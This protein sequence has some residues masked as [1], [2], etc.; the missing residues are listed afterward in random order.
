MAEIENHMK[1]VS[2]DILGFREITRHIWNT[3]FIGSSASHSM[4]LHSAF[5]IIETELLNAIIFI[6][7]GRRSPVKQYRRS[8]LQSI[9][10]KPK[11]HLVDFTVQRAIQDE[12][13]NNRWMLPQSLTTKTAEKMHFI[14]FF[15]WD[16]YG[17]L[18]MDLVR[19]E[20]VDTATIFLMPERN[21]DF[22]LKD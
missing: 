5:N 8:A 2:Q 9:I 1:D 20:T 11:K 22:F 19:V 18:S 16:P 10:V 7:N 6:S 14:D 12:H 13:G 15:D 17:F 21:C 4:G 3:C